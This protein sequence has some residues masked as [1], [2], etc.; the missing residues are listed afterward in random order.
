MGG[1]RYHGLPRRFSYINQWFK[2]LLCL[3]NFIFLLTG[4]IF[5]VF[6][7]IAFVESGGI[8][9]DSTVTA[10]Q[11]LFNL[12]VLCIGVGIITLFVSMAGFMGS[13]RENRC[14][15]KFYYIVLTVLFLVEVVCCVLF[16]I[17]RDTA[18]R[19]LEDLIRITFVTQYREPGFED[20]TNFMDFIQ[21][22]LIY[23]ECH[24]E[25]C[26]FYRLRCCGPKTYT[27]WTAN[28]YF[29]C[30]QTNTSPEAC[31]VPYSCCR[32]MNNINEYVINLSCGFGVQ[33][34]STP[35]ASGQVWTIG[36]VQAIVT[37]VEVNIVPVAGAISGIAA[38]QLVAILLAK[39]LHTQIGDQLRL[40]RQESLGL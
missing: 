24:T 8:P 11:W 17:Y 34:L 18:I 5:L 2:Y 10:L 39:T 16:F 40:L 26:N 23:S 25:Q 20:T 12:T 14:C 32:R 22:E 37:F 29:S 13:L 4:A 31:G 19:K 6:G 30:N 27:D 28:R 3:E 1:A 36:C 38:L 15:L 9:K 7:A 33:K 35:L 21:K